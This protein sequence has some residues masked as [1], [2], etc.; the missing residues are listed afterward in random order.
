[1]GFA[2]PGCQGNLESRQSLIVVNTTLS[3]QRMAV[4]PCLQEGA[5]PDSF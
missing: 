3:A 4:E 5:S 1:M 2:F